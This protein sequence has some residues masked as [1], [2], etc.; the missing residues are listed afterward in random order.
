MADTFLETGV[1][2]PELTLKNADETEVKLADF[3]GKWVV[4]YFY[5]KDNTPGCTTEALDFTA[6]KPDF[7]AAGAVIFGISPDSCKSHCNFREK[8]DL[9][10]ELLS[11]PDHVAMAAFGVWQMKKMYGREFMGVVRTT[12]LI[13]PSG[14]IAHV[15]PKV[16]VKGHAQA[17]LNELKA[18]QSE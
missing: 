10:I 4:L 11:D 15:W 8:K 14:N 1:V 16:K 13:D 6:L 12:Y 9:T 3:R 2:A 5:P 7:E 17:V 18:K